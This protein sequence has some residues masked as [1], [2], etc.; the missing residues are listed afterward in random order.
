MINAVR[1]QLSSDSQPQIR[2]SECRSICT[3][4][5]CIDVFELTFVIRQPDRVLVYL[6][7][8]NKSGHWNSSPY[9]STTREAATRRTHAIFK[10][11]IRLADERGVFKIWDRFSGIYNLSMKIAA[12]LTAG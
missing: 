8:G 5:R 4:Q 6:E 9:I 10:F 3:A 7:V 2:A 11:V 1:P 12:L